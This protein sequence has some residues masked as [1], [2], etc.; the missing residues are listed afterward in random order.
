MGGLTEACVTVF[1]RVSPSNLLASLCVLGD[2][3]LTG[4]CVSLTHAHTHVPLTRSR[5]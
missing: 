2:F 5:R 1:T 4:V 3:H